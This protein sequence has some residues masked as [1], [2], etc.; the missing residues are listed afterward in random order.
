VGPIF[1]L[2]FSEKGK[3]SKIRTP[4]RPYRSPVT[5]LTELSRLAVGKKQE[6]KQIQGTD[7]N[8]KWQ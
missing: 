7:T 5:I 1:G 4:D 8:R 6:E 3:I 2:D